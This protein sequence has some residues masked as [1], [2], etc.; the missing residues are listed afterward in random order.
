MTSARMDVVVE[1]LLPKQ[2][3]SQK[4]ADVKVVCERI[5]GALVLL[6]DDVGVETADRVF[7]RLG[8]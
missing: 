6:H 2:L 1:R 5:R 7:E 4:I 3:Q 8:N